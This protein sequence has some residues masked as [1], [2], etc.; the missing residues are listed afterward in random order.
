MFLFNTLVLNRLPSLN[1]RHHRVSHV[2]VVS[3]THK[4]VRLC[5]FQRRKGFYI[6]P[7]FRVVGS[8]PFSSSSPTYLKADLYTKSRESIV[9]NSLE[10]ICLF[11]LP[12][13]IKF[14]ITHWLIFLFPLKC[15]NFGMQF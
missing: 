8:F 7:R 13:P 3:I 5:A 15:A 1:A 9:V 6:I 12:S 11:F 10:Y 14:Y 4:R 2:I